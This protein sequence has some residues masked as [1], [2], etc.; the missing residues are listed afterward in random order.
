MLARHNSH[1]RGTLLSRRFSCSNPPPPECSRSCVL[2]LAVRWQALNVEWH[3]CRKKCC[4]S[5][6]LIPRFLASAPLCHTLPIYARAV[7]RQ[8]AWQPHALRRPSCAC[9]PVAKVCCRNFIPTLLAPPMFLFA[10]GK[11]AFSVYFTL[12]SL[13]LCALRLERKGNVKTEVS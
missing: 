2:A 6:F 4:P 11:P 12:I 10:P 8:A 9:Q 3:S 1:T 13:K 5:H 7:S